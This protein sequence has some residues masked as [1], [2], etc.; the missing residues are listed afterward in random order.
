MLVY[1]HVLVLVH[2]FEL[3]VLPA[4]VLMF[5]FVMVTPNKPQNCPWPVQHGQK[6][7]ETQLQ[8]ISGETQ[9][10]PILPQDRFKAAHA[11]PTTHQDST[12]NGALR[13]EL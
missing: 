3:V 12:I 11:S 13:A 2:V 1:V 7:P 8:D 9:D 10:S 4:I 6:S 5:V